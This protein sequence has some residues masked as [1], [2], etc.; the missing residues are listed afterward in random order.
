MR[1]ENKK[2]K[3]QDHPDQ[4][5]KRVIPEENTYSPK[6]DDTSMSSGNLVNNPRGRTRTRDLHT[7]LSV[8]GSDHD[9]Q[10]D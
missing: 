4:K 3:K 6:T 9:G 5:N 7:K 2:Q 1:N 10:A 8:T